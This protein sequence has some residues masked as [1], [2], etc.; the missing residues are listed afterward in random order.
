MGRGTTEEDDLVA[1]V[2][3]RFRQQK[4]KICWPGEFVV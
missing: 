3:L 2:L 1:E 4:S